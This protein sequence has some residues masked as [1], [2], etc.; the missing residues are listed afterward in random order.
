MHG[1]GLSALQIFKGKVT[2][3]WATKLDFQY[4]CSNDV[5]WIMDDAIIQMRIFYY[6]LLH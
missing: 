3:S 6:W 4:K 5:L 2:K 1:H